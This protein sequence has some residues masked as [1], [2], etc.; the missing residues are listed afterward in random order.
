MRMLEYPGLH[1]WDFIWRLILMCALL[2]V[3]KAYGDYAAFNSDLA[4][5]FPEMEISDM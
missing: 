2:K 3:T 1:L 4:I 5:I